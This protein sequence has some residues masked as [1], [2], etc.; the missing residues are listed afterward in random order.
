MSS[1]ANVRSI[2]ALDE[3]NNTLKRFQSDATN[4]LNTADM[5]IK[6]T[7]EWLQERLGHWQYELRRRQQALAEAQRALYACLRSENADCSE[8]Q[9]LVFR[10]QRMV[11][12][13]EHELQVVVAHSKRVDE[14]VKRYQSVAR[15]LASTLNGQLVQGTVFLSNRANILYTYAGSGGGG[16]FSSAGIPNGSKA[17]WNGF[18]NHKKLIKH[19]DKHKNEFNPPFANTQD[20]GQAA[21]RFLTGLLPVGTLEKI[22]SKSDIVRYNPTTEEYGV[23]TKRGKIRTYFIPDPKKHP[24][25]TNLD[26]F[27]AQ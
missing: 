11:Q 7:T 1:A 9:A 22:D 17:L 8:C 19:F 10:L 5:E 18:A 21:E 2:A 3:M 4:A 14:A 26:F 13:A 12:E 25:P 27:N 6:R 24:Y 15:R 20:Y 23:I 16:L